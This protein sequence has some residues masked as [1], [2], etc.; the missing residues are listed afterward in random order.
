MDSRPSNSVVEATIF[1]ILL[2]D[3]DIAISH[4]LPRYIEPDLATSAQVA[5]PEVLSFLH[6]GRII[7]K[8]K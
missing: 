3:E 8:N 6:T 4:N 2:A 1:R 7:H 5:P